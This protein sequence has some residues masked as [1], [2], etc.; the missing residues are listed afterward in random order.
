[1]FGAARLG[2]DGGRIIALL[3]ST[4]TVMAKDD[5]AHKRIVGYGDS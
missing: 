5:A 2:S 1:V 4:E 3:I